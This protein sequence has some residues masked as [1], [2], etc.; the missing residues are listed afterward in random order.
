MKSLTAFLLTWIAGFVDAIGFLHYG[1]IYT[2]NMSGNSV[3]FGIN[4]VTDARQAVQHAWPI[5]FYVIGLLW[6]RLLL[7]IGFRRNL[8]RLPALCSPWRSVC[9]RH[10]AGA[11]GRSCCTRAGNGNAECGTPDVAGNLKCIT[12]F[13]TGTLLKATEYAVQ[14][15]T[16]LYDHAFGE[17]SFED[18]SF[19][20]RTGRLSVAL[21]LRPGSLAS[22]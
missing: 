21:R 16:W 19:G 6:G 15:A 10:P 3:S 14:Y 20:R 1:R 11:N 4:T 22:G 18:P 12:G 7:E 8:D 9:G 2:A 5:A 17:R 13:V